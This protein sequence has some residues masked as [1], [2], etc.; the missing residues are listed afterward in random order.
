MSLLNR[1]NFLKS[2]G[3]GFSS[4]AL[5]SCTEKFRGL[6]SVNRAR[7]NIVFIFTDDHTNQAIGAYGS[8]LAVLNPTPNMDRMAKEGMRFDKFCVGNS[9]CAPSRATLL[10][11]KH[12]HIHGKIDNV[13]G[14]DQGQQTFPKILQSSGY[15]TAIFGKTHLPGSIEGFDAWETLPDQGD[16]YQPVF[17][18]KD[19]Q[20]QY[21]G[22]VTDIVTDRSLKWL[23]KERDPQKP[24][25]LMVHHKATHRTWC[26]AL[27]HLNKFDDVE[28]PYPDNFF[29]DYANRDAAKAQE[30]TIEKAMNLRNDLKVKTKEYRAEVDER[31]KGKEELMGGEA[32]A[33]FRMTPEQR[34]VWDAAYDPKNEKFAKANLSGIELT[35]WKYQRY[36]KDYL[37][38]ACAVDEGIGK[39]LDYLD[40]SGL[41]DNTVVMY[42]SDQG[43]YLGEHGWFDKRF[44]YEE[45]FKTPFVVRWPEVTKPGSVN[46][47]L[48]QNIDFAETFLDIA[49]VGIPDDMQGVSL[50]PLLKGKTPA[51]W[52]KS[53][54]YHYYEYPGAHSVRRHEG[55][56]GRRFKLIRF[57]GQDVSGGE[58]WEFYDLDND[59]SEMNNIYGK[60]QWSEKIS[61]MK[62]ELVR[63]KMFYKVPK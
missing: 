7:P 46:K 21:T 54:Y 45:S 43:F 41:G 36:M 9:I 2:V 53:L 10:T 3:I 20:K 8:R 56:V 5:S 40:S 14:F 33:Y 51:D 55:V 17:N 13:V 62:K 48:A 15:Q 38:T 11:G 47:D 60:A 35:K 6:A 39:I 57:Y 59:P 18:T 32:G 1:R 4:L 28:I 12:S 23:K 26:P 50:V 42:S 22:Y 44:M 52:R 16:Y 25:M 61:E 31:N 49:G 24:F 34:K 29:D 63:L 27:R 30:M 19:G 37:R 58:D